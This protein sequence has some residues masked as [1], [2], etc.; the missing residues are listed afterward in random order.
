M[1]VKNTINKYFGGKILEYKT[2]RD[3]LRRPFSCSWVGAGR[4]K[5]GSYSSEQ[6][7]QSLQPYGNCG[8]NN[9]PAVKG[10]ASHSYSH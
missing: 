9:K 3:I 8:G 1:V 10:K 4:S 5:T 2:W 6:Y 7:R